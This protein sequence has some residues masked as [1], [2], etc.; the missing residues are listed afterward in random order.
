VTLDLEYHSILTSSKVTCASARWD[1]MQI[2]LRHAQVCVCA[3]ARA[4]ACACA[5]ARA[6][7]RARVRVRV[8]VRVR[9]R[10][11]AGAHWR[12]ALGE[13][14]FSIAVSSCLGHAVGLSRSLHCITLLLLLLLHAADCP[15][16]KFCAGG[17]Y[18]PSTLQPG[19]AQCPDFMTTMGLRSQTIRQCGEQIPGGCGARRL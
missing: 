19:A 5:C 13:I 6:C 2:D 14:A 4:C 1:T 3:C 10:V 15:R 16:G 9:A 17:P 11:R 18:D 12:S 7:A 8:R